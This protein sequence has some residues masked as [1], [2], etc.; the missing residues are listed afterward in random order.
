MSEQARET[1]RGREE[2]REREE[3]KREGPSERVLS[4]FFAPFYDEQVM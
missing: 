3:R 1:E 2:E 4:K